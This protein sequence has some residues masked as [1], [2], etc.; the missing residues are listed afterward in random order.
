MATQSFLEYQGILIPT[1][2]PAGHE[3][4]LKD[5][6]NAR[7][8]SYE[9]SMGDYSMASITRAKEDVDAAKKN[10]TDAGYEIPEW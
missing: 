4:L 5:L 7:D 6:Q 10:L 1:D 2:S 8:Y 3:V 9:A